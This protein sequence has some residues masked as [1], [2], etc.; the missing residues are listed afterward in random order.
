MLELPGNGQTITGCAT[1]LYRAIAATGRYFLRGGTVM[2]LVD[3]G[4]TLTLVPVEADP[5]RSIAEHYF[6]VYA[7]RAGVN[8]EMVLKPATMTKD[9]AGAIL[10]CDERKCLPEV[11]GLSGCP[12]LMHDGRVIGPGYDPA[13]KTLVTGGQMPPEVSLKEA[14]AALL[15]LLEGF[16]F[17]SASDLSRAIAAQV[18][19]AL[20]LGGHLNLYPAFV[21][22]ADQSQTGK[23]YLQKA[24][25]AIYKES[26]RL[27]TQRQQGGVGSLDESISARMMEGRPFIQLDNLRGKQD[28]PN[29]E[30]L[31]T[32]EEDFPVRV[33]HRIEMMVD[34]S[35]FVI[36][37]T[38]NAAEMTP[39][40][41]NR[42]YISRLR[43]RPDG[44]RFKQYTEGDLLDHIRANQPYYLGC[45]FAVL[46]HWINLGKPLLD[47]AG[48]DFRQWA[49]TLGWIV[50]RIFG[51]APLMAGH[52]EAKIRLSNPAQSF[53]RQ[54][55]VAIAATG[56]LDQ[57]WT[58]KSIYELAEANE[59]PVPGLREPNDDQGARRV[60]ALMG[61][62]L[63]GKDSV[64]L[65]GI[66]I[67][68]EIR[69]VRRDDGNG[70]FDQKVYRFATPTTAATA[71]TVGLYTSME[72]PVFSRDVPTSTVAPVVVGKDAANDQPIDQPDFI[73]PAGRERFEL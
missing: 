64:M 24:I 43:K 50:V 66:T 37:M 48:H 47:E 7:R 10:A 70:H 2:T 17:L 20:R 71:T 28:S 39:D 40:M 67:N 58:A 9:I 38:S 53:A 33:P 19:P 1:R 12:L 68:L 22:E 56:G 16:D 65:D 4:G 21:T 46:R 73:G 5:L 30:A 31:M 25:A 6:Q 27:V 36:M 35:R 52:H 29:I 63:G 15:A 57:P 8:G 69:P 18:G 41:A 55:A 3:A 45:V 13:S 61:R 14:V 59:I 32:S 60:G 34:P 11:R 54:V 62:V 44:Y 51:A 42:S 26:L 72:I 49:R 23:G